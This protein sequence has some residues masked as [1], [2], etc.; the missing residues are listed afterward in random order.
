M[1]FFKWVF[2]LYV[3][4]YNTNLTDNTIFQCIPRVSL[5]RHTLSLLVWSS[6]KNRG[7]ETEGSRVRGLL[8]GAQVKD[9]FHVVIWTGCRRTH[10]QVNINFGK[11]GTIIIAAL[12]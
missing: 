9:G 1:V 11:Y 8:V 10:N 2:L 5:F 7:L 12:N 6:S 4:Y 3:I